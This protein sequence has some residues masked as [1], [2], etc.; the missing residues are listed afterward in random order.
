MRQF[1]QTLH[2]FRTAA[3]ATSAVLQFTNAYE[4][5]I[6]HYPIAEARHRAE[7]AR[8]PA[9]RAFIEKQAQVPRI[10]KRDLITFI[11]RPVTRLPRLS[12][13]LEHL[14]KLTEADHPDLESMP[15]ITGILGDLIKSTQ[16]GIEAAENKV[17]FWSIASSLVF[18][19][20]E[21]I[22]SDFVNIL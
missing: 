10:R 15:L 6:K 22:V 19:R 18:Q 1:T 4:V 9:Y 20:G 8:N 14:E 12:L 2:T 11:S 16:P 7:L 17:K 5:Y 13:V 21:I 3:H